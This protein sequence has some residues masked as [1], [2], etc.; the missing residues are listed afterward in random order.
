MADPNKSVRIKIPVKDLFFLLFL[1]GGGVVAVTVVVGGAG[2]TTATVLG[3][4]VVLTA[5][6]GEWVFWMVVAPLC[7]T[8]HRD[9]DAKA[10]VALVLPEARAPRDA[11]P[12]ITLLG[13]GKTGRLYG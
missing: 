5:G 13:V 6:G 12:I 10:R 9:V 2:G 4:M 1:G 8:I 3:G 7:S 11:M